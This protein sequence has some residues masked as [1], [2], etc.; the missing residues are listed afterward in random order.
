M[1]WNTIW[2]WL[3]NH[4]PH[5]N[6][7]SS[8]SSRGKETN[9][10]GMMIERDERNTLK[11]MGNGP[12]THKFHLKICDTDRIEVIKQLVVEGKGVPIFGETLYEIETRRSVIFIK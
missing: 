9:D 11:I 12:E 2:E 3:L 1:E 5:P 6:V 8:D 4:E 10:Q 7:L